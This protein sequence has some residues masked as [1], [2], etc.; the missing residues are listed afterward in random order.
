MPVLP[1][2]SVVASVY[3]MMNLPAATWIRFFIWM[4]IG[5]VVYFC[6]SYRNSRLRLAS[7]DAYGPPTG[8][9]ATAEQVRTGGAGPR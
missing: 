5:F 6:Y 4:A 9:A 1:A 2:V 7:T 3:L 8:P